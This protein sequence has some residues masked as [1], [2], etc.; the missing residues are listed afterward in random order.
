MHDEDREVIE[1][2]DLEGM[3][4][5]QFAKE[6]GLT[7]AG[8]KSRVQRA[9]KRLKSELIKLCKVNFDETGN[10]CCF[11]PKEIS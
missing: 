1:R 9:R 4:Q 6:K 2:C 8:A 3:L 5:A 11:T 10:V 7:L